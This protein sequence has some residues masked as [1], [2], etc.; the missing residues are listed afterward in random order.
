MR[1]VGGL[2][3]LKSEARKP[4][5]GTESAIENNAPEQIDAYQ[6]LAALLRGSLNKPGDA[7][8]AIE[9][10]VQSAPKNYLVYLARGRYRHQ[11]GSPESARPTFRRRGSWLKTRPRFIWKLAKTAAT[12]S[13][14]T[15]RDKSSSSA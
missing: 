12:E 10:M 11:L 8:Q 5:S 14:M 15:R 9:A 13:S 1:P 6:Q 7:D 4:W 2:P 3:S